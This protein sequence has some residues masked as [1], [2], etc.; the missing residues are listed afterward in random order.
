MSE[1]REGGAELMDEVAR[2]RDAL[3]RPG[4]GGE[5]EPN[6]GEFLDSLGHLFVVLDSGFRVLHVN[7]A[8]TRRLGYTAE[9]SMGRPAVE[10]T[11]PDH[12]ALAGVILG[13]AAVG[14]TTSCW[15][16]ALAK[17]G[18]S[19]PIETRFWRGR[20]GG[21]DVLFALARVTR[22]LGGAE[23]SF[24]YRGAILDAV[25]FAAEHFLE[26]GSWRDGIDDVLA[27]LGQAMEVSRVYVFENHAAAEG[28]L[29]TTQ[30][31]EWAAPGISP[32]IDNPLL[33]NASYGSP[34]FY[35]LPEVLSRGEFLYGNVRDFPE[36]FRELLV[37]EDIRSI[38][39]VPI[40]VEDQWWGFMGFDECVRE[41]EWPPV[42][43]DVLKAV[44][45]MLGAAVRRQRAAR[46][47]RENEERYRLLADSTEDFVSLNDPDGR[48]LY[49]SPSYY[50]AT[51]YTSEEVAA[52]D[53]R[54]RIHP[55]DLPR[56]EA[57]HAAN[58]EG[59]RTQ[60][61]FRVL[62]KDGAYIW[63]DLRATPLLGPDG[64]VD[65]ILCCSRDITDR[66][67]TEE[68][69]LKVRDELDLRVRERTA[70]LQFANERL[71]QE[72]GDRR[73]AERVLS[74]NEQRFRLVTLA[75]RDAVYDWDLNSDRVWVNER[76]KDLLGPVSL[77]ALAWWRERLHPEDRERVTEYMDRV[78]SAGDDHLQEEYRFH[79]P[80]G[81]YGHFVDC[82]FVLRGPS[83]QP[84]RLIGALSDITERR[85][86]QAAL[87]KRMVALTRPLG[88]TSDINFEDL[89]NL[90]DI[91]RL[92]EQ[93][94]EATGV[95]S[96]ITHTDGTPITAPSNFC[97]LCRDLIRQTDQGRANCFR[98]DAVLG[99]HNPD[100]PIVQL[101]LSGGLWDAGAAIT[102]GGKHIANWLIGQ[103]RDETQT[104]EKMREYAR[105]VGADEDDVAAAFQEVPAMS[106][107]QFERV[108]RS[109]FT[110]ANQLSD[111]AYQNIQQA[112]FIT[113][114][115]RVL[116]AL[117]RSESDYRG[118]Y[119]HAHDAIL[120]FR[121]EDE[122]ILEVNRRACEMY[123]FAREEFLGLS[124]RQI[125]EDLLRGE[126]YI[127]ETLRGGFKRDFE[128]VQLRKDGT[129][130][131]I[132]INAAVV[133]YRGHRAILSINRDITDRKQTERALRESRQM[134]QSVLDNIPQRIFWKDRA[135]A[136][137]GCNRTFARDAGVDSP[138]AIVGRTDYDMAWKK[139][140]ADW[141]RLCDRRVIESQKPEYHIIETQHHA[142][143]QEAWLETNKVPL[144][145]AD[146]NV[147]G[148]LGTYEDITDRRQAEERARQREAELARVS[149]LANLGEMAT[150]LAHELNQ[151][152][153]AMVTF[154]E[155]CILR[156]RGGETDARKLLESLNDIS[157]QGHRAGQIIRR[158]REFVRRRET[159]R[160]TTR[161]DFLV[162]EALGLLQTQLS[163]ARVALR[164]ELDE[165]APEI[166]A[167]TIQ[168]EQV[169]VNL[170]QNALD[171]M[172][173]RPPN[174]RGLTISTRALSRQMIEVAVQD[175]GCGIASENLARIGEPFFTT[176]PDGLGMGVAIS[177]RIVEA[178]G[179]ELWAESTEPQGAIFRFTLPIGKVRTV[180]K[181]RKRT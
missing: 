157:E 129:R 179:G 60:T 94:A 46:A 166:I 177:R 122:V 105:E 49:I 124:L 7:A 150:G 119:E 125:S 95:A 51:G 87:E 113:E 168:I 5:G 98:S 69:L 123:G 45:R 126:R 50:R 118:L 1:D 18:R 145:D 104:E 31:Y 83:G 16:P 75:T 117:E 36:A 101:C 8:L 66:K 158:M 120:I 141:Y 171:A 102:V 61:E 91:Q 59:R 107:A 30:S 99:R 25:S 67:T 42:E 81:E 48:R 79:L 108:A 85:R 84:V 41:R 63:V 165:K 103:V 78:F 71:R 6:M 34:A 132:A 162:R 178:H 77:P 2:V 92:Q 44:G 13:E 151:P 35:P 88:D 172:S 37:A 28:G 73:Q 93:F 54:Q 133:N 55:D 96:I 12:R 76:F 24:H 57:A 136:F 152:L 173:A 114:H 128:S 149:R 72:I 142:N 134:L 14:K 10:M 3:E 74:E 20:W 26:A 170:V 106:R 90:A 175:T 21:A 153:S 70:E 33:R 65:R 148:V 32:Q 58:V 100:G 135:G 181:R 155:A 22:D 52:V 147:V 40:F 154:A 146:G 11:A 15:L 109:L 115:K 64:R 174:Q 68:A 27:R 131:H 144:F 4:F 89:F 161:V 9:E 39:L 180:R 43:V 62:C 138:E 56:I 111:T 116:E 53:Y 137:L 47:L 38:L 167:D 97:R 160:S 156:V 19:V 29:R 163:K 86:A 80:S 17:D 23:H 139:E 130:M 121:P 169:V 159:H 112:R 82:A 164:L 176:K 110:L 140:E 127:Q 143:G